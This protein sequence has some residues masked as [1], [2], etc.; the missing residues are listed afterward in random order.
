MWKAIEEFCMSATDNTKNIADLYK[1]LEAPP[2]G[3][4]QGSIPI[5]LLS[6]L[7]YH[8]DIV[9]VYMDGTFVPVLGLEHFELFFRKPERFSIKYFEISGLRAK[10]FKE[11]E[12]IFNI[13]KTEGVDRNSTVLSIVKPLVKFATKLPQFTINTKERL[14]AE[15]IAVRN[16]LL[17][18]REPDVL[19][20]SDLP[21]A[22]GISPFLEH[23]NTDEKNVKIFKTKLVQ[24]LKELQ[25]AYETLIIDCN[26]LIHK[27]F[28]I[29]SEKDKLREDLRVR[30]TYL[31]GRVTEDLLKCFIY[32]ATEEDN[33]D[34]NWLE[35]LLM[36]V[37]DKP[38]RVWRDEDITTFDTE[39]AN[40]ARKVKNFEA[41]QKEISKANNNGFNARRVTVTKP[42]GTETNKMVWT[43]RKKQNEIDKIAQSFIDENE[44]IKEAITASL[45]DKVFGI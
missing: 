17:K 1:K 25:S 20:F 13:T 7:L 38:P 36:I 21:K 29:R 3:V 8:N 16:L 35:T 14:S 28:A 23:E 22:C 2:Y 34:R 4:K 40:I 27:A 24:V 6:V 19:L 15:A 10:V 30:A 41:I 9:S 31:S 33:D 18:A 32:A 11:L 5:L 12:S 44:N 42:D 37:A 43:D 39:L 45:I 26:E